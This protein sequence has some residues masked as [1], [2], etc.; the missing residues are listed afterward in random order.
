MGN[1]LQQGEIRLRGVAINLSTTVL[2]RVVDAIHLTF[3]RSRRRKPK[4]PRK[5]RTPRVVELLRKAL[6]WKALIESGE[7][8]NQADIARRERISR[9]RVTQVMR[10]LRLAPEIQQHVLAIPDMVHKPEITEHV[11]RP[12]T[13]IE[14]LNN[15]RMTFQEL[16]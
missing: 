2:N 12:I 1:A 4:P 10:L 5:P 13:Q 9:A 11:L 6:E 15:Q 3:Y 7:A 14:D 8:A 16:L